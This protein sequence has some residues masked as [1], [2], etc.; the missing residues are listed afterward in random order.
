MKRVDHTE[1]ELLKHH[2]ALHLENRFW[3]SGT[4][5]VIPS[6]SARAAEVWIP[7]VP[8]SPIHIIR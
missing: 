7:Q 1:W 5:C 8:A 6:D 4:Y 2:A 3:Q